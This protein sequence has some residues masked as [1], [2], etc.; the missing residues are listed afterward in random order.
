M[1]HRVPTERD[2]S[3]EFVFIES[4]EKYDQITAGNRHEFQ[5]LIEKNNALLQRNKCLEDIILNKDRTIEVLL[6]DLKAFKTLKQEHV[7]CQEHIK[8]LEIMNDEM[9]NE[10]RDFQYSKLTDMYCPKEHYI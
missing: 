1:N 7:K 9:K 6:K 3:E 5:R 10:L 8:T 4:Y 2:T